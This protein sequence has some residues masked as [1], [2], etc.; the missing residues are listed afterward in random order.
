M[1]INVTIGVQFMQKDRESDMPKMHPMEKYQMPME[2]SIPAELDPYVD[3][4][5]QSVADDSYT[6]SYD[7]PAFLVKELKKRVKKAYPDF[8]EQK[9]INDGIVE[10]AMNIAIDDVIDDKI[11]TD[12]DAIL[13][14]LHIKRPEDTDQ[15]Y[16]ANVF[17]RKID[18]S[19]LEG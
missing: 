8:M 3:K 10:A 2:V 19:V 17:V 16:L 12:K 1:K 13:D 11:E 18:W 9:P 15:L 5:V 6:P 14:G 7:A 4:Y